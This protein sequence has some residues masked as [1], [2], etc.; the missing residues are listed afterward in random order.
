V[1]SSVSYP[2]GYVLHLVPIISCDAG[3]GSVKYVVPESFRVLKK[4]LQVRSGVTIGW[5][6]GQNATGPRRER[7][8]DTTLLKRHY[9]IGWILHWRMAPSDE[10]ATGLSGI[11]IPLQVQH[12]PSARM[13]QW[14]LSALDWSHF[15]WVLLDNDV[16]ILLVA[17]FGGCDEADWLHQGHRHEVFLS[18]SS[19]CLLYIGR[20]PPKN[21]QQLSQR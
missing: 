6:Y 7:G 12:I 19:W 5:H 17:W 10:F 11:V 13:I 20:K 1:I 14:N 15:N 18:C 21:S 9:N 16:T 4:C 2:L 3:Y 8:P